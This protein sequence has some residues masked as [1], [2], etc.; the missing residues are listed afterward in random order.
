MPI[1]EYRCESCGNDFEKMVKLDAPLPACPSCGA[2]Q[3]RKLVSASSFHLKGGGWYKD[4]YGLKA[5]S[6]GGGSSSEGGSTSGGGSSSG[7]AA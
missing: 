7:G 3:T 1:Y 2:A 4:H 5:G 6:S